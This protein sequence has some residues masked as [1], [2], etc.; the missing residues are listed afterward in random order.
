LMRFWFL[1]ENRR[2]GTEGRRRV[3]AMGE[4][5]GRPL[6]PKGIAESPWAVELEFL[7]TVLGAGEDTRLK[8]EAKP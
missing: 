5:R 2:R 7:T 1:P 4:A 6:S 8:L 3:P